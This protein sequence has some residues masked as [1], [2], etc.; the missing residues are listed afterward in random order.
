MASEILDD[1]AGAACWRL[2]TDEAALDRAL[3]AGPVTFYCGFDP[4][5]P[6]LHFGNL[7]QL[8]TM[9]RLQEAGHHPI[10]VVGGATGLVGDPSGKSAERA[11]NEREVVEAWVERI[12]S[13]VSGPAAIR[14]RQPRADR[15]QPGMDARAGHAHLPARHRQ[16]LQRV[17]DA[18][19][20]V[21][22]RAHGGRGDQLH[23][24]QL[25]DPAGAGL[26]GAAIAATAP[27]CRPVGRTSGGT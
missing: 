24:V 12:A 16:A 11:L 3:S 1:L 9:R 19:Q 5:A 26:P 4:T 10:A 15:E 18:G 27:R 25:P 21:G 17:A 7:V 23:R 6:S 13:Q 8:V 2:T 14:R 22:Q 20:G